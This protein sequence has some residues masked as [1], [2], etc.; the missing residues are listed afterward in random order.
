MSHSRSDGQPRRSPVT[1]P[2]DTFPTP[3]EIASR[4]HA[5]FIAGGRRLTKI[6]EYWRQ[7]EQELLELGFRRAVGRRSTPRRPR[8]TAHDKPD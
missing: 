8:R 1:L 5:L 3:D 6:A 2:A 7:A 4:A